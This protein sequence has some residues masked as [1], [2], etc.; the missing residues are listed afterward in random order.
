MSAVPQ[1]VLVRP[2]VISPHTGET[3][4]L[5]D[6]LELHLQ[7]GDPGAIVLLGP[8][9]S[10][11]SSAIRYLAAHLP[12]GLIV[13][14]LDEPKA[15]EVAEHADRMIV[16]YA[17]EHAHFMKPIALYALAPWGD[18]ECLEYLLAAHPKR[19]ASVMKRLR[20]ATR[21]ETPETAH[22]WTIVLYEMAAEE[23]L[24]DVDGALRR[25]LNR[26]LSRRTRRIARELSF[27][28][29]AHPEGADPDESALWP[30][31]G[32]LGFFLTRGPSD[33]A[34]RLLRTPQIRLMLAAEHLAGENHE[35]IR[36]EALDRRLPVELIRKTAALV[37]GNRR[38][39]ETLAS[40]IENRVFAQ[41]MGASLL[42]AAGTSWRPE[43][44]GPVSWFWGAH[45]EGVNWPRLI[46]PSAQFTH[47]DLTGAQLE[48]STLDGADFTNTHLSRA[49]LQGSSLARIDAT[50]AD[51]HG[52]DLKD[53]FAEKACFARANLSKA[54]LEG[55]CLRH[56]RLEGA[57][58]SGA[59]FQR[60][61]LTDAVFQSHGS[62][63]QVAWKRCKAVETDFTGADLRKAKLPAM[64]LRSAIFTGCR[65]SGADL[66]ACNLEHAHLPGIDLNGADLRASLLTGSVLYGAKLRHAKLCRAQLGEIEWDRA[67]LR[68]ADFTKANFHM[69]SSRSG[70]VFGEPSEGTRSGFYSDEYYDQSYRA[71]EEIRVASLRGC[72]LRGA[73]VEGVDFYLV[74]LREARYTPAQGAWF[75]KC[76]AILQTRV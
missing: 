18:D 42:Y 4:L 56:A 28:R 40:R 31:T 8:P 20:A 53:V 60:A 35:G 2:R 76:G 19:C 36:V 33:E 41:S 57:D 44:Q 64:D 52:A 54:T 13:E 32:C 48:G 6:A 37:A 67:D 61:D 3:L 27:R 22:L 34:L 68:G 62:L 14:L 12:K 21:S 9:G 51:F 43:D 59:G 71:P 15:E 50:A 23:A 69:G 30:R 72:D 66:S 45:L 17:A 47:A 38:A 26:I 24:T 39:L 46:L 29:L 11:R 58:L 7:R 65:L 16:I 55:A 49:R 25:R 74:D 70:L 73:T 1:P 10:G 5:Q 63:E 75:H